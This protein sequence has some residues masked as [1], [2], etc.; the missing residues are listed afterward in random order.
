MKYNFRDFHVFV[1][2]SYLSKFSSLKPITIKEYKQVILDFILFPPEKNPGNLEDFIQFKQSLDEFG[3]KIP[4][5]KLKANMLIYL[6]YLLKILSIIDPLVINRNYY[7]SKNKAE[8]VQPPKNTYQV[9][10]VLKN[11]CC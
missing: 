5:E 7:K 10:L 1:L 8:K 2:K 4:T 11:Y 9:F 6:K 3:F